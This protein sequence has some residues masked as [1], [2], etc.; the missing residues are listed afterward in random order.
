MYSYQNIGSVQQHQHMRLRFV[1]AKI[2]S[3]GKTLCLHNI[4]LAS[5]ILRSTFQKPIITR[6]RTN[7]QITFFKERV[8][9]ENNHTFFIALY[10][11]NNLILLHYKLISSSLLWVTFGPMLQ[12][13]NVLVPQYYKTIRLCLSDEASIILFSMQ[14]LM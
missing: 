6:E 11:T 2:V 12:S 1:N 3:L 8:C 4:D 5:F 10:C 9:I 13:Q 7:F 14:T